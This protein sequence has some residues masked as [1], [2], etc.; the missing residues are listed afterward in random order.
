MGGMCREP[1][2]GKAMRTVLHVGPSQTRGGMG[3]VIQL[4]AGNPPNGWRAEMMASHSDGGV[5]PVLKAW[6]KV[7]RDLYDRLQ[8]RNVDIVHIHAATRWS[9]K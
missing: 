9:W 6:W 2:E 5:F 1:A 8:R 7:R 4:L 3:A